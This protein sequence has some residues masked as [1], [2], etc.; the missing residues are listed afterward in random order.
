MAAGHGHPESAGLAGFHWL[1]G[2]G[3]SCVP[4]RQRLLPESLHARD[5]KHQK[6]SKGIVTQ[7]SLHPENFVIVPSVYCLHINAGMCLTEAMITDSPLALSSNRGCPFGA[8][9]QERGSVGRQA[10][11]SSSVQTLNLHLRSTPS[12]HQCWPDLL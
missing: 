7:K 1:E 10:Q 2:G 12:S 8:C 11:M 6:A 3:G 5:G 9:M 4:G